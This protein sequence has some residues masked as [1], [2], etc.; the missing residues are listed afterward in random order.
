MAYQITASLIILHSLLRLTTKN[1]SKVHITDSWRDK[2]T[3]GQQCGKCSH[4]I[5]LSWIGWVE[6]QMN[7]R[8]DNTTTQPW[9]SYRIR[10]IAGC[11]CTGNA[12]DF[13]PPPRFSDPDML[14]GT[15]VTHVPW[16]MPGSLTSGFPRI[17]WRGKRSRHSQRTRS[18]QFYIS[19]KRPIVMW[20]ES[21]RSRVN[22]FNKHLS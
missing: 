21:K 10:K 17:R 14:H 13:S 9:A 18:P 4:V 12:V 19:G 1:Q 5:K 15:C 6:N 22:G 8:E 2:S 20:I 3:G 7:Q 16:C 11:A